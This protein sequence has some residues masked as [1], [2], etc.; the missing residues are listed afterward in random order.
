MAQ[1]RTDWHVSASAKENMHGVEEKPLLI[2]GVGEAGELA[3]YYFTHDTQREVVAFTVDARY[4]DQSRFCGLPVVAFESLMSS[5]SPEDFDVFVAMGYS[6]LNANRR[7][8]YLAVKAMGY[9]IASYISSQAY[10][11]DRR[12][13]GEN[14]FILEGCVVQPFTEIGNNVTLWSGSHIGHH[15]RI[16]DHTF[17]APHAVVSGQVRVG[18]QCFI[19][20]NATLRDHIEVGEKC[21]IGAGTTLLES[22]EPEGVYIA[23]TTERSSLVSSKLRA[24]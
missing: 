11:P 4:V 1:Q 5:H 19:G 6:K 16:G 3:H 2:F 20:I 17:V 9:G 23:Q 21:V 7:D 10:V 14:C 18:E 13:I 15:S 22:C 8:K 24:I 12:R